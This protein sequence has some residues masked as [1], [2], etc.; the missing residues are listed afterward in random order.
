MVQHDVH[1]ETWDLVLAPP[2][3][4]Q[5]KI[6]MCIIQVFVPPPPPCLSYGKVPKL[7]N[8]PYAYCS[9]A[10]IRRWHPCTGEAAATN[11]SKHSEA[12]KHSS[13]IAAEPPT[14]IAHPFGRTSCAPVLLGRVIAPLGVQD[15][16]LITPALPS[17]VS[18]VTVC[19][20]H[21]C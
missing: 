4:M 21:P 2:L 9:L 19:H 11:L 3:C 1:A 16:L 7:R 6:S 12:V 8:S 20:L 13:S 10:I 5:Q 17:G 18:S 14:G 15:G